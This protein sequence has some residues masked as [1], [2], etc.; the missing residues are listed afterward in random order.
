MGLSKQSLLGRV[1]CPWE[2]HLGEVQMES[3]HEQVTKFTIA[4]KDETVI[5]FQILSAQ[6]GTQRDGWSTIANLFALARYR[7]DSNLNSTLKNSAG[8]GWSHPLF[9]IRQPNQGD[10]I[11]FLHT[12]SR[13]PTTR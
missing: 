2:L 13:R 3:G 1:A 5:I 4:V 9:C 6:I 11:H 7:P 12:P 10:S 8:D